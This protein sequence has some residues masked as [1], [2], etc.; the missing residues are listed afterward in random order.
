MGDRRSRASYKAVEYIRSGEA[1]LEA[2]IGLDIIHLYPHLAGNALNSERTG[3]ANKAYLEYSRGFLDKPSVKSGIKDYFLGKGRH[4]TAGY[5]GKY[6][7]CRKLV[8]RLHFHPESKY[9]K[10]AMEA[11]QELI[12]L[13]NILA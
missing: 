9:Y 5:L 3:L 11:Y 13:Q 8:A 1:G 2:L 4:Y 7:G 12:D 6:S 10:A